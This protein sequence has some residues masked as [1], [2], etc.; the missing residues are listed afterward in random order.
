M[1]PDFVRR[2]VD[3]LLGG[4]AVGGADEER[5]RRWMALPAAE[6]STPHALARY[7]V[8]STDARTSARRERPAAIA[9]VAVDRMQVDISACFSAPLDGSAA[10]AK[11]AM[12]DFLEFLRKSPLVAFDAGVERP[13]LERAMKSL[14]GVPLRHPWIDA[15]ALL[16]SSFPR[17]GCTTLADWLARARVV[18]ATD[19]TIDRAFAVAQL[20]Q[21]GV[22]AAARAG[23]ANARALI[24]S[25]MPH[26]P[27]M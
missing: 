14:L 12:L 20:L 19:S 18:A 9:A 16:R 25:T 10:E 1:S 4:P 11:A 23:S 3:F 15:G 26:G 22:D 5:L 27:S 17:A 13:R 21:I 6:L 7:V 2:A 8:V 24:D